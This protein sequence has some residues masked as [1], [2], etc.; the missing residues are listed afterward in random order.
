MSDW[1]DTSQ[2]KADW[3]K[4]RGLLFDG[5]TRLP[6]L[7]PVIDEVR[8]LLE[9][10]AEIGVVYLDLSASGEMERAL[11]W[12]AHD[13]LVVTA[14]AVLRR[15]RDELLGPSDVLAQLAV[16]SDQ[17]ICFVG[18][19]DGNSLA[20][21]HDR[22]V[23][24]FREGLER[25]LAHESHS[26]PWSASASVEIATEPRMRLERCIYSAISKAR[27]SCLRQNQARLS[28][29]RSELERMLE[30]SDV[31]T[32]YQPILELGS[33]AIHGWEALS[34]APDASIFESPEILFRFA[35]ESHHVLELER[36][37][38]LRALERSAPLFAEPPLFT[39]AVL[40][41]EAGPGGKLFLNCS[42]P[43]FTDPRLIDDLVGH[44][45]RAGWR[46]ENLVLEVTERVAITEWQEFQK[47]LESVR[48]AGVRIA[49]DDMGA[50]Y[51]SLST[52]GEVEPDYLKFDFSLV[53]DLHRSPIKQDLFGTLVELAR[54]IG[55][56]PIAEGI[57]EEEELWAVRDLGV[58]LG[59]GF[60]FA[61]PAELADLLPPVFPGREA[62]K[63]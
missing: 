49:I 54:K 22:L 2:L 17:F 50:G 31:V 7:P 14:A 48:S 40:D 43:A 39:E 61:R 18:L 11:G 24:R 59:Q 23:R 53:Q 25:L 38:R 51:S 62:R 5:Q 35:E 3:L 42:A 56:R 19:D 10:G 60:L 13:Q 12:E 52:V 63:P 36:L 41:P 8:R 46:P 57:E 15:A 26:P 47:V 16:R 34:A 21:I 58:D 28:G 6:S 30:H 29:R 44:V 27:D 33:G 45:E 37:C 32:R 20:D 1:T 4:L 9:N 55:A